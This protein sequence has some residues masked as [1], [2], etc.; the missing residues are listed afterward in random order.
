MTVNIA[1]RVTYIFALVIFCNFF[2]GCFSKG[3]TPYISFLSVSSRLDSDGKANRIDVVVDLRNGRYEAFKDLSLS[4]S[5]A[6]GT[7]VSFEWP[8]LKPYGYSGAK[9]A[10]EVAAGITKDRMLGGTL[11]TLRD[12]RDG[13]L[14]IYATE[15]S[16]AL[17]TYK[18]QSGSVYKKDIGRELAQ[19]IRESF[20]QLSS[21]DLTRNKDRKQRLD[22]LNKSTK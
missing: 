14:Y 11:E 1:K 18:D 16:G 10:I 3:K 9:K 17:F 12:D 6:D 20:Q 19:T 21:E 13:A 15:V 22:K 5:F 7:E 8:E 2:A 4:I